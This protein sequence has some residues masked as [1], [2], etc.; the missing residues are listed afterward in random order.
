M[1]FPDNVDVDTWIGLFVFSGDP[2]QYL[3]P[4]SF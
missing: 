2:D 1:K 4:G 3:D